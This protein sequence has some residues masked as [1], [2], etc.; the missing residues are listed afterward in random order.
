MKV[1]MEQRFQRVA[2][3]IG[4]VPDVV[5]KAARTAT[6]QALNQ[7]RDAVY[8]RMRSVFDRPTAYA[9]GSLLVELE[10]SGKAEGLVAVRGKGDVGASGV[11]AQSYLRAQIEGGTRRWKRSERALQKSGLLPR[12]WYAIPGSA[13]RMDAFGNMSRGHVLE[14]L[15]YLRA[16]RVDNKVRRSSIT[17]EGRAKRKR[18]IGKRF[19]FEYFVV[20]PGTRGGLQPGVWVR[21][22]ATRK[23]AGPAAPVRQVLT[24]VK[25]TNYRAR[26]DFFAELQGATAKAL[27]VLLD[28]AVA[29]A[30]RGLPLSAGG[31]R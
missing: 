6:Q 2:D 10:A 12:G 22:I 13:A 23:A 9:L 27:P 4:R 3:G 8:A 5:K 29:S 14:I 26:L 28:Q 16:A 24:Y 1:G 25:A 7:G 20:L 18:G 30:R 15:D 31:T 17:D 11:P 19:G 21:Q